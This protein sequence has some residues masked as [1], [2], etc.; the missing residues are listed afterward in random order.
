MYFRQK[1]HRQDKTYNRH[2][3]TSFLYLWGFCSFSKFSGLTWTAVPLSRFRRL[4]KIH[5][6]LDL[7]KIALF[8]PLSGSSRNEDRVSPYDWFSCT[9]SDVQPGT[10]GHLHPVHAV[11]P[12]Q[13][14]VHYFPTLEIFMHYSG[15]VKPSWKRLVTVVTNVANSNIMD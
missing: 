5:C 3:L 14:Q 10:P 1:K 15:L 2:I 9:G 11:R 6:P 7:S 13:A 8:T 12:L 4:Y